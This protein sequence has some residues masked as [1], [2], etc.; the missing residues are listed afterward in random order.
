MKKLSVLNTIIVEFVSILFAVLLALGINQW[1]DNRNNHKLAVSSLEK[2]NHEISEN[3]EI[4]S[5]MITAHEKSKLKIDSLLIKYKN[6]Q[7]TVDSVDFSFVLINTTSWE[8]AKLT[9][10]IS[11]MKF[12]LVTNL[13]KIY[14][15]QNYYEEIVKVYVKD[16]LY[17]KPLIYDRRYYLKLK[18]FLETI[19]PLEKILLNYYEFTQKNLEAEKNKIAV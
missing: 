8:T 6:P 5:A 19:I 9:N 3:K 4:L 10:A 14:H 7:F 16:N 12:D 1:K 2:I 18:T 17:N 13:S 15:F 11:Y